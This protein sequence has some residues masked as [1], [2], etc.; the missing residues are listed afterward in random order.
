MQERH[1]NRKI[2]FEEQA[3]TST[4]YYIPYIQKFI[5]ITPETEVLEIGCGEGG[6]LLPFAKMGCKVTGVDLVE[7]RIEQAKRF[8][9]E[10]NLNATFIASDIF[11]LKE[12]EQHFDLVI[13]HDVIEHIPQKEKF[14]TDLHR[15]LKKDGI[16]FIAF[17]AWQMP[18]GGHQQICRSKLA[19]H[20]PFAHLLPAPVYKFYLKQCGEKQDIVNELMSIKSTRTSI[21]MFYRIVKTTGYR[22]KCK[23][24]FFIN[25]HYETKF[26]LRPRLLSPVISAVP[27]VRNFFTTSCFFIISRADLS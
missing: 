4:K 20:L 11:K 5:T 6:N 26:G 8:F 14:L 16:A 24:F 7:A 2:Y 13:V 1:Q 10:E 15:Y 18:F 9:D 3:S 12:L 19:S 17:P 25:P 27:Y 23:T 21:E 22:I